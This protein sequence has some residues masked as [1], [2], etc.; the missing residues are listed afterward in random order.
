MIFVDFDIKN[1][2]FLA[3]MAGITDLAFRTLCRECGAGLC[4]TEMVSAKALH[5]NDKKTYSLLKTSSQ[6]TPLVV[7]IFGSEP[8]IIA[9]AVK[10]IAD[11]GYKMVDINCGCPA[12]K[13]TSNGEGS[14]LMKSPLLIGEI[15]TKAVKASDIPISIKIR[16]GYDKESINAVECAKIAEECGA[17]AVTVHGRTRDEFY[18]GT[19]DWNIIKHVKENVSIPVIGNGDITYPESA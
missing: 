8:E 7:Q 15:V 16:A 10:K 9:E 18:S 13:I 4:Y 1:N 6:D 11:M 12:P 14:S 5:Y 2:F 17:S 3:P 19:S